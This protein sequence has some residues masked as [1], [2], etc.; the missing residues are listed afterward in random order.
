QV[1]ISLGLAAGTYFG[2]FEQVAPEAIKFDRIGFTFVGPWMLL[3][4]ILVPSPPRE[5]LAALLGSAAAVPMTYLA[6]VPSGLAPALPVAR[7]GLV[8]VLPYLVVVWMA[9]VAT[10]VVNQLGAEV[11][12]AQELGSYRLE[13]LLGR[14]G[15]GEVWRASHRT[16]ARPA[17]IKLIRPES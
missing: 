15:M 14:G 5:A 10:R 2:A 1:V 6:Q 11:R 7:F 16:L 3:F 17:A 12:R 4:S 9:Y 13:S 8:F